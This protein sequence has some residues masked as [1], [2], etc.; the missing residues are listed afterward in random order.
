MNTP[1]DLF[2]MFRIKSVVDQSPNKPVLRLHKS[3]LQNHPDGDNSSENIRVSA[4]DVKL[5][6]RDTFG[7]EMMEN[8]LM[9]MIKPFDEIGDDCCTVND[10]IRSINGGLLGNRLTI[11]K[12]VF[13]MLSGNRNHILLKDVLSKFNPLG[14]P[15]VKSGELDSERVFREFSGEFERDRPDGVIESIE[16]EYYY[17][18]LLFSKRMEEMMEEFNNI[19]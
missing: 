9:L 7:L 14:H 5:A 18:G 8:E 12:E 3:L 11:V 6:L 10:F 1:I 17:A 13:G 2:I 19:E 15:R 16:W 4:I